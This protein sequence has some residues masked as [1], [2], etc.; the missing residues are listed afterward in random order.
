LPASLA[1]WKVPRA[2]SPWSLFFGGAI[3]AEAQAAAQMAVAV[4]H[5]GEQDHAR[6]M[7]P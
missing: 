6:T 1:S 4:G 5:G 2:T 7:Q 3:E